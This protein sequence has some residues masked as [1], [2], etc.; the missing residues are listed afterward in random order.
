M[1]LAPTYLC[2]L[3]NLGDT[4]MFGER[5]EGQE[6]YARARRAR[7]KTSRANHYQSSLSIITTNHH[8]QSSRPIKGLCL[9]V[10]CLGSVYPCIVECIPCSWFFWG[11][12]SEPCFFICFSEVWGAISTFVYS[13]YSMYTFNL[14]E[15]NNL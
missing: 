6:R 11:G 9:V 15:Y 1:Q 13:M 7:S 10:E 8:Y 4:R 5:G 12:S 3:G 14:I 2:S